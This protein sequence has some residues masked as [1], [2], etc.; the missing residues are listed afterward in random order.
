LNEC[1]PGQLVA[2]C[3]VA[4]NEEPDD[5]WNCTTPAY[6]NP[7]VYRAVKKTTPAP[8][9]RDFAYQLALHLLESEGHHFMEIQDIVDGVSNATLDKF[10]AVITE[11][12][13]ELVF[14]E[15][16]DFLVVVPEL[17]AGAK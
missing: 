5:E 16:D 14:Y 3:P 15:L 9:N 17:E 8:A 1:V 13:S 6:C 7:G 12:C 11:V 4:E 10:A 2:C